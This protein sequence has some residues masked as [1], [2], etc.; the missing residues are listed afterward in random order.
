MR[1]GRAVGQPLRVLVVSILTRPLGRMRHGRVAVG[2]QSFLVSILTRPLGRMRRWPGSQ[3]CQ[4]PQGVSILTRPLGRMR[5]AGKRDT[6][7]AAGM[8]Q[9][10]PALSVGCD[11]ATSARVK[12]RGAVVSIL[13]RPLGRMRPQ[14]YA[15][16]LT[17]VEI[18]SILT[19]PLGRMRRPTGSRAAPPSRCFNP[20]PPSRSDATIRNIAAGPPLPTFQS[21]PAL[22]VGCD[23]AAVLVAWGVTQK[24]QSSPALSV[25]C[26]R[27]RYR[28]P[29]QEVVMVS[30]L[31]RPLGRMRR[32]PAHRFGD[33]PGDVSILT[34]P[35]GRMRPQHHVE[36]RVIRSVSILTRPLGRMRPHIFR[37]CQ[38]LQPHCF[39]PHPP[40]RS[41]ATSRDSG[42]GGGV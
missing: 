40:S 28:D 11:A 30:I 19:R 26:D 1:H 7:R 29:G 33:L 15:V 6:A 22:S 21:S 4:C 14:T 32:V 10:S 37:C 38:S 20:H 18:V 39:N 12:T 5:R 42:A 2:D 34:R 9:S 25:G 8:F 16:D 3:A 17:S 24:F 41:D 35:L 23:T 13:T 36:H 27:V 31:T